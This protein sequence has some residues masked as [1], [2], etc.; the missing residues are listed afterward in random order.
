MITFRN[1]IEKIAT[2]FLVCCLVPWTLSFL[3]LLGFGF[4][5]LSA[6]ALYFHFDPLSTQAPHMANIAFT[7]LIISYYIFPIACYGFYKKVFCS[8]P[9]QAYSFVWVIFPV[10]MGWLLMFFIYCIYFVFN[11]SSLT[12]QRQIVLILEKKFFSDTHHLSS[13]VKQPVAQ[14]TL[15]PGN[16]IQSCSDCLVIEKKLSCTCLTKNGVPNKTVFDMNV[17]QNNPPQIQNCDGQ[18][19]LTSYC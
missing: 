16:Y 14:E 19:L 10:I 12:T 18:L 1:F 5:W 3:F 13:P 4:L 9:D 6:A 11:I 17:L 15:P 7:C 2:V 8:Q